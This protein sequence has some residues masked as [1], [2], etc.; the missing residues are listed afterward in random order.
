MSYSTIK[1]R[2][3]ADIQDIT[4]IRNVYSYENPNLAGYPA[5]CVV[6]VN[7]NDIWLDSMTNEREYVFKVRVYQEM[8]KTTPENADGIID[9]L[10]D[11]L[12][13]KFAS[14]YTLNGTCKGCWVKSVLGWV[15]REGTIRTYELEIIAKDLISI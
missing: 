7:V 9:N 1:N 3:V 12:M 4:G 2:I 10:I 14:D 8:E 6:A 15:D 11:A 5:A 13:N